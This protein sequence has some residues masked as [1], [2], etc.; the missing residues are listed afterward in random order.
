MPERSPLP[1]DARGRWKV[2]SQPA[3]DPPRCTVWCE[4][5]VEASAATIER[6]VTG[7]YV[8]ELAIEMSRPAAPR[9]A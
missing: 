7:A 4:V 9:V 5:V 2:G 6:D 8:H 1:R 3:A